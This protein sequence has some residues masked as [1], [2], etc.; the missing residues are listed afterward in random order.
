METMTTEAQNAWAQHLE[1]AT[2]REIRQM[3]EWAIEHIDDPKEVATLRD[4]VDEHYWS[5]VYDVAS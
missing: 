1:G 2:Q 3:A 5:L 4:Q